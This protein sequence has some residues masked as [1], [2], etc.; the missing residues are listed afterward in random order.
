MATDQ[1]STTQADERE[2]T[3]A[4]RSARLDLEN[5][6]LR[7]SSAGDSL[8]ER[9]LV[10]LGCNLYGEDCGDEVPAAGFHNR[11]LFRYAAATTKAVAMALQG[12]HY[13]TTN[14]P[15]DVDFSTEDAA[16]VL[17]GLSAL[18]QEGP[19]LVEDLQYAAT[20]GA[21]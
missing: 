18:L 9:L 10:L 21:K 13:V 8:R 1:V 4:E 19:G 3:H 16:T 17:C 5:A 7:P 6:A 15:F 14:E 20:R 11:A 12:T 2:E